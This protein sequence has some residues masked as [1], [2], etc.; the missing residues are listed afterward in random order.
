M[1]DS[2]LTILS[3]KLKIDLHYY[4][5]GGFWLSLMQAITVLGS[6]IVSVVLANMLDEAEYGV[7]RYIIGI[8]ILLTSFSLTGMGQSIFQT[9]SKGYSGFYTLGL[10]KSLIYSVGITITGIIGTIYYYFQNNIELAIGCLL[11]A[12]FQPLLNTFQQIFPFL[13]G[14]QKFLES[15]ILQGVKTVIVTV[16]TVATV[17]ITK[18]AI[19]L[20]LVY[21]LLHTSTNFLV[22]LFFRPKKDLPVEEEV[23]TRYMNYAWNSSVRGII[24]NIAFRIDSIIVF[25]QLGAVELAIYTIANI[26]PEHI[27]GSF[28]NVVTLLVPKYALHENIESIKK[29]IAK[30]SLQLF[31]LTAVITFLYILLSP[32]LYT[33]LF[34]K[35]PD[36]ILLSQLVALSF[37]AMLALIPVS[38]LQAHTEEKKLTSVNTQSSVLMIF[39][40]ILL[41]ITHGLYGA[42][43]A[44]VISRYINLVLSYYHFYKR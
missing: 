11:I 12:L 21:L 43:I 2:L 28:K 16:V 23:R 15:T 9:A 25:Q 8:G 39:F 4:A 27:K 32:Y 36:A 29:S 26:V 37:P 6:L 24:G 14:E 3:K 41:T 13:Q 35:Y 34:P 31:L 40:T 44:R 33:L 1:I 20:V 18:D 42:I 19:W 5:K 38:A 30:R 17:L 10:R 22:H 7:Y